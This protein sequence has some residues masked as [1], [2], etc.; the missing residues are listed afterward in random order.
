M[1]P[2]EKYIDGFV[3]ASMDSRT[4]WGDTE[5]DFVKKRVLVSAD[6]N[7]IGDWEL[8]ARIE[9]EVKGVILLNHER[10]IYRIPFPPNRFFL[11]E[12]LLLIRKY[13]KFFQG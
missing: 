3:V 4:E 6:K 13:P 9:I 1:E 10:E 11:R 12:M 2:N 5:D 8:V 7:D